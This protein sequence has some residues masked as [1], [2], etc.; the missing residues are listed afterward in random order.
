MKSISFLI[1]LLC[2]IEVSLSQEISSKVFPD[3]YFG[4]YTGT[5]SI[6]T[7]K[8]STQVPMEFHLKATDSI[9]KYQY[10]L[11]YGE[12]ETR[13]VRE[14]T[15]VEKNK[16]NGHYQIDENNGIILDTKWLNNKLYCLFE[17][18]KNI[19]TSFLIFHDDYIDFE[20]V[21]SN[22]ENKNISGGTE[23]EIPEVFS[24]PITVV[25]TASLKKQ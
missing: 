1:A 12:N 19:L 13:Q 6:N 24:Y 22:T 11:V 14:Y 8:G 17:V 21:F 4:I 5:L 20:I 7:E 15:L 25:Q 10:I 9:G 23:E 2:I 18:N 16:K 3:S